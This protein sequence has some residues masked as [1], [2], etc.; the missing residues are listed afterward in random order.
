M[1]HAFPTERASIIQHIIDYASRPLDIVDVMDVG[2]RPWHLKTNLLRSLTYDDEFL[3]SMY[4]LV[5]GV[6]AGATTMPVNSYLFDRTVY[7]FLAQ[8]TY[9]P[10]PCMEIMELIDLLPPLQF[11]FP[12][13]NNTLHAD[14]TYFGSTSAAQELIWDAALVR[15]AYNDLRHAIAV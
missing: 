12:G 7:T 6:E 13:I 8:P 3:V 5:N 9:Y 14:S 10:S 15:N 1:E 11:H 2:D 4:P